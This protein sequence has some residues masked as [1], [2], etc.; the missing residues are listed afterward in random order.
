MFKN[1]YFDEHLLSAA[2]RLGLFAIFNSLTQGMWKLNKTAQKQP[3]E[4]FCCKD[5]LK[6]SGKFTVKDLRW[7]LFFN[8][9]AH[10]RYL[11]LIA[12]QVSS[13][14]S[15]YQ[16][17]CIRISFFIISFYLFVSLF[18]VNREEQL[19]N[20]FFLLNPGIRMKKYF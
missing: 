7:I 3:P 1:T 19:M 10:R 13:S 11:F 8:K 18:P 4:I 2:T 16:T 17:A 14:E 20:F 15:L 9:V 6:N 12:F 5:V